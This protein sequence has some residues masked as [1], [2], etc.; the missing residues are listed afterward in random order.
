MKY[1]ENTNISDS[2][3]G[4]KSIQYGRFTT[5]PG[6]HVFAKTFGSSHPFPLETVNVSRTGFLVKPAT[7]HKVPFQNNTL[8][9]MTVLPDPTSVDSEFTCLAKVIRDFHEG[10]VNDLRNNLRYYTT[11]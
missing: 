9:E 11:H 5:N 2:Q 3:K 8:L 10:F 7:M 6:L 4:E 1:A